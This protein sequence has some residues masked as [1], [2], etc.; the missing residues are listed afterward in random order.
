MPSQDDF[1]TVP[2]W[3]DI[4]ILQIVFSE[5]YYLVFSEL[6]M[7]SL[8]SVS[9][10]IHMF[11]LFYQKVHSIVIAIVFILGFQFK[12]VI[13]F[14]LDDLFTKV[15]DSIYS[16]FGVEFSGFE[17]TP[18]PLIPAYSNKNDN[19]DNYFGNCI[20]DD[21]IDPDTLWNVYDCIYAKKS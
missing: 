3:I 2:R 1:C 12:D 16:L 20:I 4:Y 11:Q 5:R 8:V 10:Y 21:G 9:Q 15:L 17:G 19:S 7:D 13:K 6:Y 14:Y 18:P